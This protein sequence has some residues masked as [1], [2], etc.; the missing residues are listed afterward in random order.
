MPRRSASDPESNAWHAVFASMEVVVLHALLS[1]SV[2][3]GHL[4]G[5]LDT[6]TF[7]GDMGEIYREG[8]RPNL[9]KSRRTEIL[10][11]LPLE[12]AASQLSWC[13]SP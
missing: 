7:F 11:L 10:I 8:N 9:W 6:R 5:L 12:V 3:G 13:I 2:Y 1:L 4:Y